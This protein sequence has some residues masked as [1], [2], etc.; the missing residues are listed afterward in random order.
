[1]LEESNTSQ[2]DRPS[3]T[4]VLLG[5]SYHEGTESGPLLRKDSIYQRA[6]PALKE[7]AGVGSIP[8]NPDARNVPSFRRWRFEMKPSPFFFYQR[9]TEP[10]LWLDEDKK[11]EQDMRSDSEPLGEMDRTYLQSKQLEQ[12]LEQG[13]NFKFQQGM[14]LQ[15][16]HQ[17]G[18]TF[19][20]DKESEFWNQEGNTCLQS[21]NPRTT[22]LGIG[23]IWL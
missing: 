2:Q 15:L 1:V 21:T 4:A 23:T 13:S 5:S 10:E 17:T 16:S 19:Q 12:Q 8:A 6:Y 9:D 18:N 20:Q 14:R 7:R 11:I 3:R 22:S